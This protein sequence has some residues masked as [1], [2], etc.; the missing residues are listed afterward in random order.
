MGETIDLEAANLRL[1]QRRRDL[2]DGTTTASE[3]TLAGQ[4]AVQAVADIAAKRT[5]PECADCR[6]ALPDA[7]VELWFAEDRRGRPVCE[8]CEGRRRKE[9]AERRLAEIDTLLKRAGVDAEFASAKSSDFPPG[10]KAEAEAFLASCRT[11]TAKGLLVAGAWGAGKTRL[12][13]AFVRH[14]LIAGRS[15]KFVMAKE[16]LGGIWGTYRDGSEK[17]EAAVITEL[18]RVNLLVIDDLGKEGRVSEG[19]AAVWHS[20]LSRRSG[21]FRPTIVTTNCSL[22][23]LEARYDYSI[24][25]RLLAFETITM[26]GEDR[27][28]RRKA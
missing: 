27:R 21:N 28:Q 26:V 12:A 10:T 17:S 8:K 25:S 22:T 13:C 1:L 16:L 23:D 5:Q 24:V 7:R 3:P 4:S 9:A 19:G 20:V 2:R 11:G 6:A 15:A 18:L 14:W